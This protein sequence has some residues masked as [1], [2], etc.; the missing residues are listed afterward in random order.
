VRTDIQPAILDGDPL[1]VQQLVT[2]LIDNAV[3]HNIA[4]G[5]I[6]IAT[7]TSNGRAALAVNNSWQVIPPGEVDRLFQAFQRLGPRRARRDG[8]HGLGLA[9]VRRL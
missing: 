8:G 9:I 4:A 2:N 5:D 3:R 7:A 1:L 6:H